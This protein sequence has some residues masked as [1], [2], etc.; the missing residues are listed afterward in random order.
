MSQLELTLYVDRQF[1]SPWAMS[2]FVALVE[3]KVP[4]TL[5]TIDLDAGEARAAPFRDLSL[6]A[7][8]P[9]LRHGDFVLSESGAI[10]EYL[11]DVFGAPAPSVLPRD[12]R[13]RARARQVQ[14]WIRSDL[15]VLRHERDTRVVFR[16][17]PGAPLSPAAQAAAA[18]LL[19]VA[20]ALLQGEHLCG[21][22]SLADSDLALMLNRL[23]FCGDP[24]PQR[25]RDYAAAQWA[26]PSV[27][28]WLEHAGRAA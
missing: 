20:G 12:V 18:S 15:L 19:R 23:I 4:F 6:T 26:R 3:K 1:L 22:W 2:A 5:E 10:V 24:V 16:A 27:R 17:M 11:D 9:A 28:A 14:S 8:V 7:R 21:G 25:L 13:Q